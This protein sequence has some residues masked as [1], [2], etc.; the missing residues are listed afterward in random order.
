MNRKQR[1]VT[2]TKGNYHALYHRRC[3]L[4]SVAIRLSDIFHAG[5][6]HPHF[7]GHCHHC[8]SIAYHQ[9][10]PSALNTAAI[11]NNFPDLIS[12]QQHKIQC[13]QHNCFQLVSIVNQGFFFPLCVR[14]HRRNEH[15]RSYSVR[16]PTANAQVHTTPPFL[17][18]KADPYRRIR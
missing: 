16:Y 7:I 8:C 4:D 12:H 6:F 9:W 3:P 10:T 5:R 11:K 18:K 1:S 17:N 13:K 14:P 15:I 2:Y